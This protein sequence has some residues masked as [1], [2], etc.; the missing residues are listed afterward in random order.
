MSD[1]VLYFLTSKGRKVKKVKYTRLAVRSAESVKAQMPYLQTTIFTDFNIKKYECFDNV[2]HVEKRFKDIWVYKYDCLLKS[3]YERTLHL[4]ADTYMC[5][6]IPEVFQA[7]DRFDLV[8]TLSPHYGLGREPQKVARCFP[9]IAGGFLAWKKNAKMEKLW[10]DMKRLVPTRPKFRADEPVLRKVLYES[11]VRYA[12]IPWEYHCIYL[13]PGY[14]WSKVKVMHGKDIGTNE[15]IVAAAK[16]MNENKNWRVFSGE[17]LFQLRKAGRSKK[18][19]KFDKAIHYGF[20][21]KE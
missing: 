15:D 4:D 6:K 20:Y 19:I 2:F 1:G 13:T 16:I 7:L 11:D 9:E 8:T 14:L 5:D 10:T 12:I 17:T 18:R 3:P 21:E